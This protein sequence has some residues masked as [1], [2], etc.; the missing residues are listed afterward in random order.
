LAH[1]RALFLLFRYLIQHMAMFA[2]V[3][4]ALVS[5]T[6]LALAGF[7]IWPWIDLP[8]TW[9]GAYVPQAGMYVQIGAAVLTV[10]LLA[11]LPTNRRVLQ[12]ENSHRTFHVGMQDIVRAYGA[13]HAADRGQMFQLSGEF[14]AVRER[15]AYLHDHPDLRD[16]EPEV[17]DLAAQ[18]SFL[19]RELADT[20]S[21]DKVARARAFLTQRQ[22]EVETF[23]TRLDKAKGI[24]NELNHWRTQI[25]LEESVAAAQLE[26]LRET[27]DGLVQDQGTETVVSL[28]RDTP[29][30]P[31][32]AE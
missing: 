6:A 12:L 2:V 30:L 32:A 16:L 21:D 19:S 4:A 25:E 24:A 20:Y 3:A 27:L 22:E 23:N 18:M 13:V 28:D 14:E 8:L 11:Y 26:R 1:L 9:N 29:A 10:G 17:L 15:L 7:G 31:R 5:V